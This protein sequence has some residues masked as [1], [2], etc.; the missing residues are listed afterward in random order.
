M[1]ND[2]AN[3]TDRQK[4]LEELIRRGNDDDDDGEIQETEVPDFNQINEMLARSPEEYDM[5]CQMDAEM[6]EREG[7][8]ERLEEV[9]RMKP[10]LAD[11]STYNYRLI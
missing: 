1:F 3:D 4:K 7:A 8:K 6:M 10:G 2:N 5:F 11:Y 9:E